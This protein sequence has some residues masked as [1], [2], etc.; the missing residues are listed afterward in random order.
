MGK[1]S[2]AVI[3]MA[4]M[5]RNLALNL[6]DHGFTVGVYNRSYAASEAAVT[7]DQT[8]R[9]HAF[10]E[11]TELIAALERPRKILMLIKA[12]EPVDQMLAH[13][14]P[15]L[16]PGDIVADCG[17]SYFLDSERRAEEMAASHLHF[18]G[19]G[20]SGGEEGARFGPAIM[21]GGD[22]LAYE[23]LSPMLE[24]ISATAEGDPCCAYTARGGAGHYVKM[25]HNGIEYADMQI[26]AE[27][28]ALLRA[29]GLQP[30]AMAEIFRQFNEGALNS[31]LIEI[32][33]TVLNT[34]D[35]LA[36]GYL[37][38]Q[39]VDRAEQKG[40]GQW[41]NLEAVKLGLDASVLLAGLNARV[42]SN[43]KA[44]RETA[45]RL[46]K[47]EEVSLDIDE[48]LLEDLESALLA[49]K[50]IAY[51]QGFALYRQAA[52]VYDWNLDYAK[53]AGIFRNGCIIRAGL[54]REIMASFRAEPD[55]RNLLLAPDFVKLMR[56]HMPGL[57]RIVALAAQ[58]AI[59]AP[60]LSAAL[61]YFD[62]Y[63][64]AE[65]STNLI[66]GLRDHFGA[67]QYERR[68][69]SGSYHY[70]WPIE[71]DNES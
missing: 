54:L 47:D 61:S 10:S 50:I 57:R 42:I 1:L 67:H 60:A 41:T 58:S 2:I 65:G 55:L 32:T 11:L 62:S 12:G 3:G 34:R 9:L 25:V 19:I 48:T 15:L 18:L 44:E 26:I 71:Y 5:G 30:N 64:T 63:S 29:A 56:E 38:D 7:A 14:R 45:E 21:P 46:Y 51:A 36:P 70:P 49:A 20:V 22:R 13:L 35:D 69:R 37:I 17:N 23:A 16:D 4:V 66:Q 33:A 8:G 40:T 27:A 31:Y 53:I 39:I 24:A 52:E 28:Y 68:D 6:A 59:A 43:L